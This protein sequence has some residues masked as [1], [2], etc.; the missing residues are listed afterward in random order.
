MRD[1]TEWVEIVEAGWNTLAGP[2]TD[3][4]IAAVRAQSGPRR[5]R[6]AL[7]G[8]GR[9]ERIVEILSRP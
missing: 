5:P 6:R 4:I 3:A 1:E 9:A 7:Y 2:D 8:D